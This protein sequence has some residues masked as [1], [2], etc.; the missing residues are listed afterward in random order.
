MSHKL[1]PATP[2]DSEAINKLYRDTWVSTYPNAEHGVSRED[3][4]EFLKPDLTREAIDG[5][6]KWLA[7]LPANLR[8]TVVKD[9]GELIGFCYVKAGDADSNNKLRAIYVS[10]SHQGEGVGKE[11][12]RDA[13]TFLNPAKD[14]DVEVIAYNQQA[15]EFYKRLGFVDEGIRVTDNK[16]FRLKSGVILPLAYLK[17]PN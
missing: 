17:R 11:L 14:T 1:S 9:D 2:A 5:H 6:K 8:V 3:I 7:S 16:S 12:W 10:P 4:E 15:I 13:L